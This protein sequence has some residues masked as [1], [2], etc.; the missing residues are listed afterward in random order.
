MSEYTPLLFGFLLREESLLPY[1][2]FFDSLP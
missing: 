2:M 1:N